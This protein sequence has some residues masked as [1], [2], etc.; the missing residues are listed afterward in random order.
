M[1]KIFLFAIAVIASTAAF[2]QVNWGLQAHGNLARTSISGEGTEAFKKSANIGFGAG[3]IAD[4]NLGSQLSLRTSLNLLQKG[5]KLSFNGGG[6]GDDFLPSI[7]ASNKLFYAELPVN[8]VYNVNLSSGKLFFGAGPSLGYGLFGKAKVTYTNPFD[9]SEKET[10]ETDAFKKEDDGGAGMKR[11]DF[12][13]NA[14]AGYQFNN[15]LFIN[16][17]YLLGF[18]NLVDS[19]D[20]ESMKN[21]GLQLTVGFLFNKKK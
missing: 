20:G 21:R 4:A 3:V 1:K 19:E 9:P 16:A 11:F 12:S 10:E 14:I 2:S 7:D 6:E 13:A 8:L 15:G 18:G 17:G 5:G